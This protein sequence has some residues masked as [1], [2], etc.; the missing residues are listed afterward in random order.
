MRAVWQTAFGGPEVLVVRQ[1]PDPVAGAGQVV[2]RVAAASI[3]FIETLTRAGR[4]PQANQGPQPPFIPGNGVGGSVAAVG[5]GVDPLL[6]G[7][8]VVTTTGGTGGYA[9]AVAVPAAGLIPVPA[10]LGVADATALLADGRTATGLAETAAVQAGERILVLAAAGGVGSLLIQLARAAGATVIGA[11]GGAGE[12]DK[13][14]VITAKGAVA[15]DYTNPGWS[16]G[17]DPVDVV[18]DG[19]G[20]DIGHA[21]LGLLRP[22]GRFVQYGLASGRPTTVDREDITLLGFANLRMLGE[23]A[24]EL[25]TRAL[26]AAAAGQLSVVIGQ[27]FPL[28][29][30]AAAHAAIEARA[31]IGKTLLIP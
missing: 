11:A 25:T 28:D 29:Q 7:Q 13:L 10:G 6:L 19:V 3:T 4:S 12:P 2:V 20:G 17:L 31:T 24:T 8:T 15:V 22:G 18:F 16:D 23:R 5:E 21:A 14:A 1:A 9:S 26:A 27:T 30:A